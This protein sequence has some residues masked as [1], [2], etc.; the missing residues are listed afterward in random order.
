MDCFPALGRREAVLLLVLVQACGYAG[1]L[2]HAG[3]PVSPGAQER[4]AAA[5]GRGRAPPAFVAPAVD[6]RQR[7]AGS[8]RPGVC[9]QMQMQQSGHGADGAAAA[10][11]AL[12]SAEARDGAGAPAATSAPVPDAA[13]RA[14]A[15]GGAAREGGALASRR[16]AISV[17]LGLLLGPMIPMMTTALTGEPA[18]HA[19]AA[20]AAGSGGGEKKPFEQKSL[21]E[22]L[23]KSAARALGG[24]KSGAAAG[25]LQVISLMWLRTTMNYQYR[26]GGSTT[27]VLKRLY[28]EGGVGRFYRGLGFALIQQP[29]SRFGNS[30]DRTPAYASSACL[31]PT[32]CICTCAHMRGPCVLLP[33]PRP[34]PHTHKHDT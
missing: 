24:G 9:M 23:Q 29:L 22:I 14:D 11:G 12:D 19:A 17:G 10:D 20:A 18:A 3:K 31:A 4:R 30:S 28:G 34:P 5:L 16:A 2:R 32:P 8:S 1:A 7:G 6:V 27:E 21:K 33:S 25:V 15:E 26:Y 13:E